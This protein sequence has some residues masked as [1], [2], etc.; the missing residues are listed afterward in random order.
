MV[1]DSLQ[2]GKYS[3]MKKQFDTVRRLRSA[4]SNQ[5]RASSLANENPQVLA[6]NFSRLAVDPAGSLWFTRFMEG[7]RRRMGQDRRPNMT[8]SNPLAHAVARMAERRAARTHNNRDEAKWILF[9]A[10]V[11]ISYVL[12]LRGSEGLLLDLGAIGRQKAKDTHVRLIFALHGKVK[13]EHHERQH[14][15]PC[16]TK[17]QSGFDVVLWRNRVI[18][19]NEL[20]NRDRGQRLWIM[21]EITPPP[22]L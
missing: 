1:L 8:L 5:V 18:Q 15:F 22:V 20:L 12:S 9:G 16:T 19:S 21:L 11:V 14:L 17:T 3:D 7:C 10:Y 2:P 4:F 13:G 6:D